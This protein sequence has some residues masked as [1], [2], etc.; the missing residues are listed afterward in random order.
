MTKHYLFARAWYEAE[1]RGGELSA[2]A[3]AAIDFMAPIMNY[4]LIGVSFMLLMFFLMFFF[5]LFERPRNH[6]DD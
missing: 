5:A 2:G 6:R 1:P 3:K 4:V